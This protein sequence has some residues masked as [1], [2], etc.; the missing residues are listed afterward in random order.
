MAYEWK[1]SF[2][3]KFRR[4]A[5]AKRYERGAV[6]V[7]SKEKVFYGSGAA[8]LKRE[9]ERAQPAAIIPSQLGKSV[10]TGK[11]T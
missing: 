5:G 3:E 1:I 4:V 2:E 9:S 11:A 10:G 8:G 6:V 7:S